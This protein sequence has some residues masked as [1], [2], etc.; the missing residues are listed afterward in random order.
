MSD[1]PRLSENFFI[2]C[3]DS[4]ILSFSL[5]GGVSLSCSLIENI[6]QSIDNYCIYISS[7]NPEHCIQF[8]LLLPNINKKYNGINFYFVV[9]DD[10]IKSHQLPNNFI[11]L[12]FFEKNKNKFGCIEE[13]TINPKTNPVQNYCEKNE[14]ELCVSNEHPFSKGNEIVVY[15]KSYNLNKSLND[16][17]L[18]KIKKIF[19][20]KLIIDPIDF[21]DAKYIIGPE[22]CQIFQSAVK[23]IPTFIISNNGNYVSL[24]LKMFPMHKKLEL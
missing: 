11:N 18:Q 20:H 14:I 3:T 5:I 8:K 23:K 1:G 7:N 19:G 10:I 2:P 4:I 15:T 9:K 13:L 22:C 6:S 16:N 17:D 21:S 24:F 12:E